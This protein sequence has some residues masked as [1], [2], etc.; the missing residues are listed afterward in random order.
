MSMD[1]NRWINTLPIVDEKNQDKCKLN[2]DKWVGSIPKK[3]VSI[4]KKRYT[5]TIVLFVICLIGVPLIKNDTRNLQK[6]INNLQ[7]SINALKLDLHQETLD[8]EVITSPEN[9]SK[10]AKE[11]LDFDLAFYTKSQIKELSEKGLFVSKTEEIKFKKI[12]V[13]NS[14]NL[15]D[16]IKKEVSKRV[17]EKRKNIKKITKLYS[18]P[19][20][21]PKEIKSQMTK[22]IDKTKIGLKNLYNDP[23]GSISQEGIQKWAAVQVVKA[24][25]GIPIIP[26]K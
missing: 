6:E 7:A 10:L 15:K 17:D 16:K 23:M 5:F 19:E 12:N 11:Y 13:N 18:E 26:G 14:K 1:P 25:F 24:F 4:A 8:H 22:K 21:L 9:I 2:P 3:N 20:N